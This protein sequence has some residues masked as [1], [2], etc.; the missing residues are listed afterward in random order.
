[1]TD[2]AEKRSDRRLRYRWPVH[3]SQRIEDTPSR[4]R[5]V[6]ISSTGAAFICSNPE[7]CPPPGKA[8]VC[9]FSVPRFDSDKS[10]DAASF[11]RIARVCRIDKMGDLRRI[12][13]QFVTPLPLKPDEQPISKYD[14]RYRLATKSRRLPMA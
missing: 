10:F 5:M 11:K 14:R 4:G 9:R 2:I 12:A 3:F 6:D 1:M 7:Y 13:V 8:L